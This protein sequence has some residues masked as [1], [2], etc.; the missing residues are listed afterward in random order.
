MI[1]L[2]EISNDKKDLTMDK[3]QKDNEDLK[4]ALNDSVNKAKYLLADFENYKKQIDK[5]LC[6]AIENS[7]ESLLKQLLN[8]V[9]DFERCI[10][11]LKDN[12]NGIL[13]IYK[14]L[15]KLLQDNNVKKIDCVGKEFDHN[16]AEVLLTEESN[17]KDNIVL[18]E[19]QKGYLYNNK[20]LRYA[21]V[22][23]AKHKD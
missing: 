2:T 14:N 8:I 3:L 22:K 19:L 12:E 18:E 20:V 23:I 13:I 15:M 16:Y 1:I 4:L 7:N 10:I 17:E 5:Q 6:K 9:D 11:N 21:K